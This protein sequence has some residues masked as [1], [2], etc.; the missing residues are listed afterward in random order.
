MHGLLADDFELTVTDTPEPA[1]RPGFYET[2][3]RT[4]YVT[5]DGGVYL[6]AAPGQRAMLW[7]VE[8][9]PPDATQSRVDDPRLQTLADVADDLASQPHRPYSS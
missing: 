9:L 4:F 5:A 2:R 8:H 7:A 6:I 3:T 1:A